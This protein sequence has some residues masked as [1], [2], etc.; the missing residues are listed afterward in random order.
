MTVIYKEDDGD[1]E[2]LRGR[3]IGIIGYGNLGRPIALN[4]RDS[5]MRVQVAVRTDE[6]QELAQIDGLIPS[7]IEQLVR[8]ID[9]LLMLLPDEVMAKVYLEKVSPHLRRGHILIFA[10]A[11]NVAFGYIEPPPFVDVGLIAPRTIGHAVRDRYKTG[12]GF[13]SFIA[14]GQDASGNLWAVLLAVAKAMGSLRAGAVEIT[15]EQ[16]A[17]LDLFIQQAILPTLHHMMVTAAHLLT[18]RGYPPEAVMMDLYI[19]G[20]FTDYLA[21]AGEAGM[22]HALSQA[23]LTGQFGILSRME[24]FKD[25][26]LERLMEVTLREIRQG[27]FATEWAQEYAEGYPRLQK[28][29]KIQK[30]MD[31]WELEQQTIDYLRGYD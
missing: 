29:L 12:R 10:S 16:E 31:L 18:E 26:K 19:S 21:S 1:L 25:M 28:L 14:A 30:D 22:L 5:G 11:Y 15:M 17:E 23:S 6:A 4:L 9:I 24:R 20:E 2:V 3:T 13:Y 27:K 7:P 8:E